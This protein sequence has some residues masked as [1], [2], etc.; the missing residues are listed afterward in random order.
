MM[1][2]CFQEQ[3]VFLNLGKMINMTTRNEEIDKIIEDLTYF[4]TKINFGVSALD[5]KAISIMN[6]LEKK[7]TNLKDK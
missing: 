2:L 4:Y 1:I 3:I 5:A 6:T 7:I